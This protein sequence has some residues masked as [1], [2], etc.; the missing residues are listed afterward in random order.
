MRDD[1]LPEKVTMNQSGA[2]QA[3]NDQIIEDEDI[4]VIVRQVKYLNNIVKQD[5]RAI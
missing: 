5:H 2:Y 3:A 1:D 4:S